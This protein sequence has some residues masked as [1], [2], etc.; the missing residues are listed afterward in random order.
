M[1]LERPFAHASRNHYLSVARDAAIYRQGERATCWY[2]VASGIA[3]IC[4]FHSDGRRQ[5]TGFAVRGDVLGIERGIRETAAE[6][7][8][9]MRLVR[10]DLSDS[11]VALPPSGPLQEGDSAWERALRASHES[12]ALLGFPKAVQRVGAF[13]LLMMRRLESGTRL[14]LPMPRIDIADHLGLTM[15]TVSRAFSE[16]A[17]RRL[18]ELQ[19]PHHVRIVNLPELVAF[20]GADMT[21][22]VPR[23]HQLVA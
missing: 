12:L 14:E 5:V 4:Q 16:L 19:G 7:L 2:E 23:G 8:T 21:E 22:V 6:A 11:T 20:T 15:H 13:L 10:H 17:R 18:I 3:R 1:N 9:T